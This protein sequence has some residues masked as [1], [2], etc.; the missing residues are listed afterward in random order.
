M[1]VFLMVVFLTAVL[2]A[3]LVVIVFMLHLV[4]QY[5]VLPFTLTA[6]VLILVLFIDIRIGIPIFL[7]ALHINTSLVFFVTVV[8]FVVT[9]VGALVAIFAAGAAEASPATPR[10]RLQ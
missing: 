2:P 6:R 4:Q 5:I 7:Q 9:L 10:L 3:V 1:V 8:F